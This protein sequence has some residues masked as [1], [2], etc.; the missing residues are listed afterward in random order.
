M[1]APASTSNLTFSK[2]ED[3]A[4]LKAKVLIGTISPKPFSSTPQLVEFGFPPYFS[5][6]ARISFEGLKIDKPAILHSLQNI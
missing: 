3:T 6:K 2:D 1:F 5:N 4:A